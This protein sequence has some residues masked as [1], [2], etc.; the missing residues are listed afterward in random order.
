MQKF[1]LWKLFLGAIIFAFVW[2]GSKLQY[3]PFI[4]IIWGSFILLLAVDNLYLAEPKAFIKPFIITAAIFILGTA[5]SAPYLCSLYDGMQHTGLHMKLSVN[6]A[7]S[8]APSNLYP[9]YLATLF[10]PN[11]FGSITG[12]NF[13]FKRLMFWDAN[14]SAGVAVTLAVIL[15][16]L[17]SII[18]AKE[19]KYQ[20]KYAILGI[21]LYLFSILCA[22]GGNT[23][24]YKLAFGWIPV[25][26]GLPYPIRFRFIQCFA[27]SLL[28]AIGVNS[29]VNSGSL[30]QRYKLH[31]FVW[32]YVVLSFCVIGA[33]LFLPQN[34][35]GDNL[36]LE[37]PNYNIEGFFSLKQPVGAYTPKIARVKKIRMM[38]NGESEG[39]I[40]Y[41]DNHM[42]LPKEGSLIKKYHVLRAGWAEFN[43][44]V[45]PN[46]FLWVYSK[47]GSGKIGYWKAK[48][49]CFNHN[50]AWVINTYNNAISFS[51]NAPPQRSSLFF[52]IKNGYIAAIPVVRPL[53]YWLL[54]LFIIVVSVYLMSPR[55]FGYFLGIIVLSELFVFGTMAFYGCTF[56]EDTTSTRAFLPHNV[57]ALRPST[58]PMLQLMINQLP[59]VATDEKLRI[60]TD[61]PFYDN[62]AYLN[63][64]FAFMGEPAFPLEKRFKHAI[65]TVY[66]ETMGQALFYDGGGYFPK[67]Q[68]FLNNFS[69]GYFLSSTPKEIFIGEKGIPFSY[70]NSNFFVHIN[71]SALPRIYTID[72]LIIASDKEQFRELLYGDLRKA[73]YVTPEE[74]IG[75]R[76]RVEKDYIPHFKNLQWVNPIKQVNFSNPNQINIDV[77]IAIPSMLVLTEVWYPGWETTVDNKQTKIYRVNYCQRGI[78]LEK[79]SHHVK[80]EFRPLAWRI[81]IGISLGTMGLML[82]LLMV[83]IPKKR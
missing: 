76:E 32:L 43:V 71:H 60:A 14:M 10:V 3:M 45:P 15:G 82:G 17:F 7:T 75:S 12:V 42:V 56:N 58:H 66:G 25:V 62:F 54:T 38:F 74:G 55:K 48:Q 50:N 69:V 46:K 59:T 83:N 57:R 1:R 65:E 68:E 26:G 47:S 63:N 6:Y 22:L 40:R 73:V 52:R 77:N 30:I 29:L 2:L 44:D 11:L 23:P 13:I 24:F 80:L 81:G 31:K 51:Q 20:Q 79:G 64:K 5:L 19:N 33:V 28:I 61:Y 8:Y 39:E 34:N 36:S 41:S 35:N 27:A 53:L 37:K 4:M 9:S 78:W 18:K 67:N 16:A 72:T 70:N 49:V 21:F